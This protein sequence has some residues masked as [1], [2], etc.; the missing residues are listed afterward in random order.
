MVSK[1]DFAKIMGILS[2]V[3]DKEVTKVM[4]DVY[5]DCLKDFS[6]ENLKS[7]TMRTI[8]TNVYNVMPKPAE[9]LKFLEGSTDDKAFIA[10][11]TAVEAVSK[12]G[13]T[14]DPVFDDPIISNCI[15]HICGGW[16][17]F[18]QLN[19]KDIH[20]Y[21]KRFT[22]A[23]K[24][25]SNIGIDKEKKL[26]GFINNSNM[27]KFPYACTDPVH[28]GSI[29]KKDEDHHGRSIQDNRM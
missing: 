4:F 13:Y 17:K 16:V 12:C 20:Y 15:V 19:T 7:A 25:F 1:K 26:I 2:E 14:H 23:Y 24:S 21:Q 5:Y 3:Y 18:C 8:K 6:F 10:W 29:N 11:G 22:D 27:H 28:I 9:L